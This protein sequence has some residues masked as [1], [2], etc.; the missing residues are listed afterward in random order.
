M[1][2]SF[3]E[4]MNQYGNQY[5]IQKQLDNGKLFKLEAGIYST[6][7]CVSELE[8]IIFKNPNAIFTM[9]SAF[10]YHGLTD[11]IPSSYCLATPRSARPIADNRVK[12]FYHRKDIFSI[13]KTFTRQNSVSIPI[14]DCERMLIELIRNKNKLPFDF[15]K[16]IIEN[17]RRRI[18]RM[19]IENLQNYLM[20]FP[21]QNQIFE[22]IQL[23]VF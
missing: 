12:Q 7:P 19:D 20:V 22:S 1:L 11:V 17:Y 5:Q 3:A 21:R 14:Y 2:L 9:D 18:N 6:V 16:E 8:Q 10:F 4:C 23:E 13:G 15:Y